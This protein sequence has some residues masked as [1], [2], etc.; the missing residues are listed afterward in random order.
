[1]CATS[2]AQSQSFEV[3]SPDGNQKINVYVGK[4]NADAPLQINYATFYKGQPVVLKSRMDLTVDNYVWE[5][6]LGKR[7]KQPRRWFDDLE[8]FSVEKKHYKNTWQNKFGERS[9][10][11]ENYNGVILHFVKNNGSEYRLDIEVR[12]Y[13]E[14]V[15]FRYILPMHPEAIFHRVKADNTEFAFPVGTQIWHAMWAQARYKFI[16]LCDM[17]DESERPATLKISEGL[18]AAIG[19]A[20]LIDFSR[21]KFKLSQRRANCL[22]MSLNDNGTDIV[23]PQALPW[24]LIMAAE[25]A[26]GL[27]ENNDLYLH[28]NEASQ[29]EDESWIVPGKIM[30]ETRLTTENSIAIIDFCAKHNIKYLLYDWKWYGPSFDFAS[31]AREVVAPIDMPYVIE[32]GKSKGVGI[33]VYVNQHALQK[34]GGE[35]LFSVYEDWGLAGVKFGFVQCGSQLWNDWLHKLVRT[36]A[37]HHIMCN[38]H[39]EYRPT[40]YSRTYPNLMT[41]EGICGNEEF[42]AASNNTILPFTRGLCGAGDYTVCY[43]DPRLVNTTHAHQLALPVV[44]FSPLT[45]LYWYDYPERIV[46]VPELEFFDNVPTVWDDTKVVD[47]AMGEHIAIARRSGSEWFLGVLNGDEAYVETIATK[48]LE[49]GKAY[50]ASVYT[51]DESVETETHVKCAKYIVYGWDNM[52]FNLVAGGGAAVQFNPASAADLK[53]YPKLKLNAKL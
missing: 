11:T 6:A 3:V 48:F 51:D 16:P 30:R 12:A 36:A 46:E 33:W 5:N 47:D 2:F 19:E 24:R 13:N 27:L 17:E 42:P 37:D 43:F 35:E 29:I 44:M 34:Q 1:M 20:G 18:W 9:S 49:A 39:D 32:Y 7:W 52:T 31:D 26:G 14:G 8:L 15:A 25:S 10:V 21:G 28:L 50:V 23:T 41:Q 4:E 22:E 40:G 53:A 45:T 38:I